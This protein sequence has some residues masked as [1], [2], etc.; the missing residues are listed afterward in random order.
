MALV[1]GLRDVGQRISELFDAFY[2][3]H[4]E[5]ALLARDI[6]TN[7][8]RGLSETPVAEWRRQ[9][10]ALLGAK[11]FNAIAAC[12]CSPPASAAACC[13]LILLPAPATCSCSCV[14]Q[15]W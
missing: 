9:L 15:T 6:G 8:Y 1:P 7:N 11:V 5:A 4:P 13:Y 10:R 3:S 14:R 12:H 2:E